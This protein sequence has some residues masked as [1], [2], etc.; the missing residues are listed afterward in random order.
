MTPEGKMQALPGLSGTVRIQ[1]TT[2]DGKDLSG[3]G[4]THSVITAQDSTWARGIHKF[5][6]QDP[7]VHD[8]MYDVANS[9]SPE[10]F[11]ITWSGNTRI[12]TER[13]WIT[14]VHELPMRSQGSREM[15][16]ETADLLWAMNRT[17]RTRP[18]R[19]AAYDI[20]VNIAKDYGMGLKCTSDT[21]VS[22]IQSRETDYE[23]L[24][25]R[26]SK[27]MLSQ[28]PY[29]GDFRLQVRSTP[30]GTAFLCFA[31]FRDKAAV[32]N[33]WYLNIT[34]PAL[35]I[36][37]Q[38]EFVNQVPIRMQAGASGVRVIVA[39]PY[40]KQFGDVQSPDFKAMEAE[41][42]QNP[43]QKA[44]IEAGGTATVPFQYTVCDTVQENSVDAALALATGTAE[45]AR[46]GNYEAVFTI[47]SQPWFVPGDKVTLEAVAYTPSALDWFVRKC[48][49][50]ISEGAC[51]THVVMVTDE[52]LIKQNGQLVQYADSAVNPSRSLATPLKP[53]PAVRT[54]DTGAGSGVSVLVIYDPLQAK[55]EGEG[56]VLKYKGLEYASP[57]PPPTRL[58]PLPPKAKPTS[59]MIQARDLVTELPEK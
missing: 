12:S 38:I 34:D 27:S 39:D 21:V 46:M 53:A 24:V 44:T 26:L 50:T 45:A 14:A 40:R 13:Q 7:E 31:P 16:V 57:P 18:Q 25:N 35:G 43:Q 15:R 36:H 59:D 11:V 33:W 56:E 9:V 6:Y 4:H 47:A 30:E 52:P 2:L 20:L 37:G 22:Y 29:R 58:P 17:Q 48:V 23:F 5:A 51:N 41:A 8:R 1:I 28:Y 10:V 49:T 32:G 54:A 42:L 3:T 19:G 55:G